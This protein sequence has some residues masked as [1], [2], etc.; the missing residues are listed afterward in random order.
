VTIDPKQTSV[1]DIEALAAAAGESY[2]LFIKTD[3]AI[4]NDLSHMLTIAFNAAGLQ[5]CL[6]TY[7]DT[8][9]IQAFVNHDAVVYKCYCIG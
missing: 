5:D 1:E 8:I 3:T 2:P 4:R 9:L 7:S 6:N